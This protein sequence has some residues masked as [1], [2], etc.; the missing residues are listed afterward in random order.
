MSSTGNFI[1][2]YPSWL[3]VNYVLGYNIQST[4]NTTSQIAQEFPNFDYYQ[5]F[6]LRFNINSLLRYDQTGNQNNIIKVP[7]NNPQG[8]VQYFFDNADCKFEILDNR[9]LASFTVE[10]LDSDY[11]PVDLNGREISLTMQFFL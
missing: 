2:M 3:S 4:T 1:L 7:V 9:P 11:Y 10:L 5:Y 8:T 6:Y